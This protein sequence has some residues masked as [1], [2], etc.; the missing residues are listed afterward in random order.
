MNSNPEFIHVKI[1]IRQNNYVLKII[2]RTFFILL[3][4]ISIISW[5]PEHDNIFLNQ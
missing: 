5:N 4:P 3:I 2:N 1:K